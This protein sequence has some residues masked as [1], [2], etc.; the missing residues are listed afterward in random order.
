[1][2]KVNLPF[3]EEALG[4]S[5]ES[6]STATA[7]SGPACFQRRPRVQPACPKSKPAEAGSAVELRNISPMAVAAPGADSSL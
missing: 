1:M 7:R 6:K 4:S 3:P 5:A 2:E